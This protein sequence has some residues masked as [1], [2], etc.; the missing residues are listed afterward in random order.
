MQTQSQWHI[1]DTNDKI[2]WPNSA[3][4]FNIVTFNAGQ[5]K[6]CLMSRRAGQVVIPAAMV[7]FFSVHWG[8][9]GSLY[10]ATFH[11]NESTANCNTSDIASPRFLT[12]P[13]EEL[14]IFSNM[15]MMFT[16]EATN[17]YHRERK[18][19]S[20]F[21]IISEVLKTQRL[22]ILQQSA[23]HNSE[24]LCSDPIGWKMLSQQTRSTN[25]SKKQT[26]RPL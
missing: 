24:I 20:I 13:N 6:P 2:L 1:T 25:S 23:Q 8:Y 3:V 14:V 19:P 4:W 18:K 10:I 7:S 17:Q 26:D 11:Y 16:T 15:S 22:N 21:M 5:R 9:I 12:K